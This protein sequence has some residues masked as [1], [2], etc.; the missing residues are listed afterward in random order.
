MVTDLLENFGPKKLDFLKPFL[1]PI[2][3]TII[4]STVATIK[5]EIMNF[6]KCVLKWL[7]DTFVKNYTKSLKKA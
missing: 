2:E 4:N 3:N 5:Q 1:V 7:G 6:Y